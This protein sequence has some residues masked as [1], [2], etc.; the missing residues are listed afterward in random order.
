MSIYERHYNIGLQISD[1]P[2]RLAQW[3]QWSAR[4]RENLDIRLDIPYGPGPREKLDVIVPDEPN[5][6]VTVYWHGGF[7]RRVAKED[8]YFVVPA[9]LRRGSV[10]VM[11][12]YGLAPTYRVSEIIEHVRSAH[13]WIFRHIAEFGGDPNQVFGVGHSVGGLLLA[14]MMATDWKQRARDLPPSLLIGGVAFSG[15]YNMGPV[16]KTTLN[17]DLRMDKSEARAASPIFKRNRGPARF[18]YV[19]GAKESDGFKRQS[20]KMAGKHGWEGDCEELP[21]ADHLSVLDPFLSPESALWQG[22]SIAGV[23]IG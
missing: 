15:V 5:G 20:Q 2:T 4:A 18:H 21:G 6:S 9:L 13:E 7:F 16:A 11:G 8:N 10:V 17:A 19:Y 12:E 22:G 1:V 3:A 14:E 23:R